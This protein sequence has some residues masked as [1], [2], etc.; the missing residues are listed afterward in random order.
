MKRYVLVREPW[1]VTDVKKKYS[2]IVGPYLVAEHE[3]G[4]PAKL[5]ERL[6]AAIHNAEQCVPPCDVWEV[7]TE[8]M[9]FVELVWRKGGR[10]HE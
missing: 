5:F 3:E 9:E 2:R 8:T 6:S 7:D 4:H 1:V 10:K